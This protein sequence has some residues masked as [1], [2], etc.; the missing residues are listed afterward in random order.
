MADCFDDTDMPVAVDDI[1]VVEEFELNLSKKKKKKK[2]KAPEE[3]VIDDA[4]VASETPW[5]ESDR[6]Y[7]YTE[8]LER[9]FAL[10]RERN[11]GISTRKRHTMPPPQMVRVGTR[12][13]M[14]A[15]FAPICQ[16]MR[17]QNEHVQS[18]MLAELGTEG[19]LDGDAPLPHY[20]QTK[21]TAPPTTPHGTK[22]PM[23][24]GGG[25]LCVAFHLF[26]HPLTGNQRLVVKG[27]YVHRQIESLLKKYIME[28]VSCHMCR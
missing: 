9:V 7:S 13:T 4:V 11:P 3:E 6:D 24:G 20:T 23:P 2:K 27:R 19:S 1:A 17:R 25:V 28:Y 21:H 18:F 14:W 16:L 5:A 12:K 26:A 8:M 22:R 15:N 10:L